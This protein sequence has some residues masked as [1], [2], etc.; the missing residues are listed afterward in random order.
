MK[1][2]FTLLVFG[3]LFSACES[4]NEPNQNNDK[5]N[6]ELEQN[7][8]T[9]R[10]KEEE[11]LSLLE[12]AD[13]VLK[14]LS[15]QS[16]EDLIMFQTEKKDIF[17]SPYLTFTKEDAACFS[18]TALAENK[19]NNAILYWGVQ[20]GTGDPLNLTVNQ[21]FDRYVNRGDYLSEEVK[22][23]ENDIQTLGNS[24]NVI[25]EVFPNHEY[26][27]Y[28]LPHDKDDAAEMSWKTLI[29]VFE[30]INNE[31]KI[32]AVVNHEWTI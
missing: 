21:Y 23:L 18:P 8:D 24:M 9:I 13:L 14:A 2:Y 16:F 32:K 26:V 11:P 7:D 6:D 31:L 20:D 4:T 5:N 28:N 3:F 10:E 25:P 17:F 1:Y 22:I 19:E 30:R 29:L 27:S 15:T 12:S